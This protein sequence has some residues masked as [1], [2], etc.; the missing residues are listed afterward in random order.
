MKSD[1][2]D[3]DIKTIAKYLDAEWEFKNNSY[4]IKLVHTKENRKLSLEIHPSID[5]G[6][7]IGHL[8]TV[9]ADK[10][11]MQLHSFQNYLISKYL[12]EV[13]FYTEHH[14]KVSGLVIDKDGNCS[15]YSNVDRS[16][17]SGNYEKYSAEVMMSSI[18][19]S[20]SEQEI[21]SET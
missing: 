7:E 5:L 6:N 20:L 16:L 10:I 18:A 17:L 19:L 1:F 9:N 8:I 12:C 11:Y 3:N 21:N 4:R 2:N 14:G 13:L 15:L